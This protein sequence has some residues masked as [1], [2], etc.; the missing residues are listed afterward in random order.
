ML[1]LDKLQLMKKLP[2]Y[3]HTSKIINWYLNKNALE[4]TTL[5]NKIENVNNQLLVNSAD[6]ELL[7]YEREYGIRTNTDKTLAERRAIIQAKRLSQGICTPKMILNVCLSFVSNVEIIE[8][9]KQGF[10]EVNIIVNGELPYSLESLYSAVNEIKPSHVDVK[11]NLMTINNGKLYV[12]G[13]NI[14]IEQ[15]TIYPQEV[16]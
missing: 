5:E 15:T 1:H 13:T 2:Q 4:I 7:T 16:I 11:Y 12:G 9:S 6:D 10:F 8:H 3:Y 14:S